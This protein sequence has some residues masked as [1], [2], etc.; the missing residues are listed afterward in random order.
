[1]TTTNKERNMHP[2]I[3][4]ELLRAERHDL[5]RRLR[6]AHHETTSDEPVPEPRRTLRRRIGD[7]WT[8]RGFW[9]PAA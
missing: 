3:R 2:A 6:F 7:G 1:M 9:R 4:E 5:E 8:P